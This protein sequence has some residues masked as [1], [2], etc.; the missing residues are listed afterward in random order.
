MSNSQTINTW[1]VWTSVHVCVCWRGDIGLLERRSGYG[2]INHSVSIWWLKGMGVEE[3]VR[4]YFINFV[5]FFPQLKKREKKKPHILK[6]PYWLAFL[7]HFFYPVSKQ[8]V[9]NFLNIVF[10]NVKVL[11][12]FSSQQSFISLCKNISWLAVQAGL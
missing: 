5:I 8:Y 10:K 11:N 9:A 1:C 6:M 2:V 12:T 7:W 4:F 3:A